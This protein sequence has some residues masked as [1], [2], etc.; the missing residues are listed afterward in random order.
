MQP[1]YLRIACGLDIGSKNFHACFRALKASGELVILRQKHFPNS[2]TGIQQFVGWL[3]K[4]RSKKGL[5]SISFF[6]IVM[7]STGVYHELLLEELYK[8]KF[9]VCL[10]IATK[11]SAYLKTIGHVSKNDK[12]D[13]L[14]ISQLG[15]ERL[16]KRWQPCSPHF[17]AIRSILRHC[18]SLTDSLVQYKNRL[19]AALV[20]TSVDEQTTDSIGR[21]ISLIETEITLAEKRAVMLYRQDEVLVDKL[22]SIEKSLHGV[23]ILTLLRVVAETNGFAQITSR[24]QLASFAG[25]DIIENQSGD[26][27]RRAHIS[28]RGNVR[29]RAAMYM[30]AVTIIRDKA[31][32]LYDLYARIRLRNP[33]TYKI[34]NVAVQRKLLLLIY[35]LYKTGAA[36]DPCYEAKR[37]HESAKVSQQLEL[38]LG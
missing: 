6:Q 17:L 25:Y 28:K 18:N 29:L 26:M 1:E 12:Q 20:S 15:I 16:L 24:D 32:H 3:D 14:G 4:I 35:T 7:E 8:Q 27:E 11:V 31:G 19:H 9:P 5:A 23:R 2:L 21:M 13:A 37:R 38:A 10:E 22:S 33:K 34:G 36:Y 30:P